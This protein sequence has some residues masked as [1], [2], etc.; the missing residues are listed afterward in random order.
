MNRLLEEY[1]ADIL[2][3][4]KNG[5][6]VINMKG[7][8]IGNS[9]EKLVQLVDERFL[10]SNYSRLLLD[11][12]RVGHLSSFSFGIIAHLWKTLRENGKNLL[13]VADARLKA[14]MERLGLSDSIGLK[15]I[16]L[17]QVHAAPMPY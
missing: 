3:D 17:T 10:H 6:F 1:R 11:L 8:L 4:E 7:D 15:T 12:S 9:A 5:C 2:T 16:G 13:V 14:K